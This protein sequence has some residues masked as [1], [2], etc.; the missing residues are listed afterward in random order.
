MTQGGEHPSPVCFFGGASVTPGPGRCPFRRQEPVATL[1]FEMPYALPNPS[2]TILARA[3]EEQ[4]GHKAAGAVRFSRFSGGGSP[5]WE[6]AWGVPRAASPGGRWNRPSA[7][8]G[9]AAA[10]RCRQG[11]RAAGPPPGLEAG[12]PSQAARA[13]RPRRPFPCP[14]SYLVTSPPCRRA[15]EVR[16]AG[17]ERAGECSRRAGAWGLAGRAWGAREGAGPARR[18]AREREG[19]SGAARRRV[20]AGRAAR[21]LRSRSGAAAAA[22]ELRLAGRAGP[23]TGECATRGPRAPLAAGEGREER[24]AAFKPKPCLRVMAGWRSPPPSRGQ[25]HP[26]RRTP[27]CGLASAPAAASLMAPLESGWRVPASRRPWRGG[28][29]GW[30]RAPPIGMSRGGWAPDARRCHAGLWP[31]RAASGPPAAH[32]GALAAVAASGRRSWRRVSSQPSKPLVRVLTNPFWFVFLYNLG[33]QV[34]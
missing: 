12:G 6:G 28:G 11:A 7:R 15:P 17:A 33:T 31:C 4:A 13:A 29:G 26:L 2:K 20:P 14:H 8:E 25:S 19:R 23:G 34:I 5:G 9:P 24:M 16:G 32:P 1:G 21:S 10:Q 27:R 22:S 18:S 30:A 3:R